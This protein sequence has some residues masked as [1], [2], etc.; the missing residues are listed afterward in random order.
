MLGLFRLR[1][2][3]EQGY[4][5]GVH[6]EH[7]DAA[8][9]GYDKDSPDPGR[10]R[11]HRGPLRMLGWLA[12]LVYN[13]AADWAGSLAGAWEG[14]HVRTLRRTFWDRPGALYQTPEALIV[15]LDRFGG[16]EALEPAVDAFNAA[17]HRLR[18]LEN[19]RV[20]VSLTPGGLP[21]AGP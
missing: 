15:Q 18:W 11:F 21:R 3:H 14:C 4:R 20:V 19:R 6:D 16:Q 13:A 8:P 10:P 7:L 5:V 12:A 1:Q 17:G 9:C 2:R